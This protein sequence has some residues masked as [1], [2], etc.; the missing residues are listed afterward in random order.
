MT[1][2]S[3]VPKLMTGVVT[4]AHVMAMA[5]PVNLLYFCLCPKTFRL[6]TWE[7][8]KDKT[9]HMPKIDIASFHADLHLRALL[10]LKMIQ[11]S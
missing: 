3:L 5:G 9:L 8:A 7:Y 1:K 4:V 11:A 6:E 10:L 2:S